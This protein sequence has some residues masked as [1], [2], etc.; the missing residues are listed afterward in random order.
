VLTPRDVLGPDQLIAK[1]LQ[2]YEHRGQQLEMADAVWDSLSNSRHL[3]VE[4]ATG[5]GKSLGYLV[6]AVLFATEAVPDAKRKRRVVISTNTISL[7]EQLLVKDIPLLRS[8]MPDEFTAVLAKG[9]RNYVSLR[10]LDSALHRSQ[11]IFNED[12]PIDQLRHLK[13]WSQQTGDG[14]K[15]GL[16]WRP[17]GVVWDEVA[18]D[19]GNCMGR[20]CP[21]YSSCFYFRSRRRMQNAQLIIVNHALFFSDLALRRIGANLLPDYDAVVLDEAH[22]IESVASEHLGLS[23]GLS[24]ID[25]ALNKL[26]NQRGNKGLLV[27]H[28][29]AREQQ[30]VMRCSIKADEFFDD[31]RAWA[32]RTSPDDAGQ[33]RTIRVRQAGIVVNELSAA[34]D[35]LAGRLKRIAAAIED[36]TQRQDFI[37]SHDRLVVLASAIE[38]WRI[39]ADPHSVYWLQTTQRRSGLNI[40]LNAAP[41]DIG[42]IIREELFDKID[43]VI[44]TS[45]TLSHR[46]DSQKNEF[47]SDEDRDPGFDF[48]KS[49]IGLTKCTTLQL[50][51]S[52]NYSTQVRLVLVSDIADP[53]SDRSTHERQSIAAIKKYVGETDGG[54]FVLF[55]SYESLR[56]AAGKLAPFLAEQNMQL[57]SQAD[58][59]PRSKL[60]EQ[61]R[62]DGRAVLF[63]TSSFWQGVDVPGDA[64]RNVIITK[65]PFSVPDHPLLEARLESIK[66]AG[67]NPFMEY[68]LPEA[69]IKFKQGFGRLIRT[70]HDQGIVV[71]LDPRVTTR[72]YGR[73]FIDSLPECELS[74]ESI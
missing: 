44:L 26:Y 68:Q 66:E 47:V 29:L 33:S 58:G 20:K 49:R 10:R 53:A 38:S 65:L 51:S 32:R 13:S 18:S 71:V 6:P 62:E 8:V 41:I 67:G 9:R 1:R 55:T 31:V 7:Q 63:G 72:S 37:A 52:F 39:Q 46:G 35:E 17:S 61:F 16:D 3:V 54:A 27:H 50:G 19:N 12:E 59:V 48:F 14:S 30:M 25:F 5:V 15:A 60:L 22:T 70:A 21:T 40:E 36:E 28:K 45:A 34:L 11:S 43:S 4:A 73:L 69:I 56:H 64:L 2:H 57:L 42:P 24:Q 74:V 23:V